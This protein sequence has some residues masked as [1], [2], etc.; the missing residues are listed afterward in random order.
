[1]KDHPIHTLSLEE[2]LTKCIGIPVGKDSQ[3][4]FHMT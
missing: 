2:D 4:V 3:P 1:M